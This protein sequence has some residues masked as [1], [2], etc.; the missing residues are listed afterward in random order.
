MVKATLDRIIEEVK[1]LP[2]DEW[3]QL[4]EMLDAMMMPAEGEDKR[5]ALHQALR[6]AGLVT[7]VRQPRAADTPHRRRIEAQGKPVSETIIEERR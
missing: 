5:K 1:T 7:Q 3:R 4:R 2:P 6:A